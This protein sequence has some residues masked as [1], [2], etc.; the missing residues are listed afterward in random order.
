MSAARGLAAAAGEWAA[1]LAHQR[2]LSPHTLRAYA[3]TLDRFDSFLMAHVGGAVSLAHLETLR[4]ADIRSYLTFRRA[5]GL[6]N[7]SLARELSALRT[8]IRW[9][10]QTQALKSEAL[11]GV[12]SPK[13]ARR[14]PRPLAAPDAH[15]LIDVVA[16]T[17]Q[18]DWVRLRNTAVLLLLWGAGLRI[19]E[20]LSLTGADLPLGEVLTITGKRGKTRQVPLLPIVREAVTAY[21]AALPFTTTRESPLFRG[22]RGGPLDAGIIRSA[23]QAARPALGLPPTATPHALRHSFATHL[24]AA[25]A[26][27]RSLQDLLGHASLS[28]TQ[29]YTAVDSG[30][31]L[32]AYRGAHPRA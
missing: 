19:S 10:R 14:V 26:D 13:L 5:E 22:T 31:L 25:G 3:A 30:M 17:E 11:A 28:S 6:G 7:A 18:P 29:I 2:R 16:D 15:A 24:L 4:P 20:A 32:D 23:M 21:L 1:S 12:K 27:L 8:F 9:A